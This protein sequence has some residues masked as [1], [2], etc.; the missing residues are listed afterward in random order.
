M[1][2][3]CKGREGKKRKKRKTRKESI[4][5][6]Y[7]KESNQRPGFIFYSRTGFNFFRPE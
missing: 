7:K 3:I 2:D 5:K 1:E 6:L 4:G